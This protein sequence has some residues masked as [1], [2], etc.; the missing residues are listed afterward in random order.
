ME[1]K[2][3]QR[4]KAMRLAQG[5]TLKEL[6][7]RTDLSISFL[8]MVER[9]LTSLAIVSLKKI[10]DALS[11]NVS[12]FFIDGGSCESASPDPRVVINRG[13]SPNIRNI[14]GNYV[15]YSLGS[16]S[17]N[18]ALDPMM[19]ILL[20]GQSR[21]DVIMLKHRGEEFTYVLEGMLSLFV[22]NNEHLL[23]PGDSY[24]GIG[25]IQH[26]FVN[27]TNNIVRVLFVLTPPLSDSAMTAVHG[28]EKGR[29]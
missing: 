4:I 24:H 23:Y 17:K 2:L 28:H 20:P 27:L 16:T 3:G 18:F 25:D 22:N 10:A 19:I 29:D 13:Y 9:G 1:K 14:S 11:Q 7:K 5:L 21:K 26:N 8:S 15:Y 6:S 12:V